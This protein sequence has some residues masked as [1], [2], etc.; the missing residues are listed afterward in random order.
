MQSRSSVQSEYKMKVRNEAGWIESHPQNV[1]IPQLSAMAAKV[2]AGSGD[3]WS[4][5]GEESN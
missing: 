4:W 2:K 1:G 3:G 5:Q